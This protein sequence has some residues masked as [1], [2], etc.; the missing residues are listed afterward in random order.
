MR[1]KNML[2]SQDIAQAD[3]VY[4]LFKIIELVKNG[5]WR[6]VHFKHDLGITHRQGKYYKSATETLGLTIRE[7]LTDSG[8][9]LANFSNLDQRIFMKEIILHSRA[10]KA[11]LEVKVDDKGETF[12]KFKSC[13]AIG[14]LSDATI[15]RR[16]QT[17]E[18]WLRYCNGLSEKLEIG[19]AKIITIEKDLDKLDHSRNQHE[20]LVKM[21]KNQ[22]QNKKGLDVFE[23]PLVDLICL[24]G[25]T[26][27]FFEMKSIN[28]E[29]KGNQFKKALGQLI[30]YKNLIDK[31]AHL[32]VVLEKYFDDI[33]YLIDD[34]IHVIWKE[35]DSFESDLKTKSKLGV[36]FN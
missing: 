31:N 19:K 29:N 22:L 35:N 33:D 21:M 13:I 25:N 8:K 14:E 10:M 36:V 20:M 30:F 2:L 32:V 26:T 3:N 11:Y 7:Q 27:T 4:R 5:R 18:A 12:T 34:T 6:Y 16:I 24:N 15:K 1:F 9:K 23:D 17:L 28:D